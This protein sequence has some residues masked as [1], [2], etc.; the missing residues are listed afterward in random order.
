VIALDTD[1][2]VD[3]GYAATCVALYHSSPS[4]DP[5]QELHRL[6]MHWQVGT[7]TQCDEN[8][9]FE[10]YLNNGVWT[11]KITQDPRHNAVACSP[12]APYAEHTYLE[13]SHNVG[14]AV[15]GMFG[16]TP[17]D[18][19]AYAIQQHELDFYMVMCGAVCVKYNIDPLDSDNVKTHAEWAIIDDYFGERWDFARLNPSPDP[20]SVDEAILTAQ[21]MRHRMLV[22]K[23]AI[24]RAL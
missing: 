11:A 16:A 15:S 7:L 24:Q 4:L 14:C 22:C 10:T 8:Y 20:L 21:S 12:A 5:G 9:N 23:T 13:N 2:P 3:P 1:A 17:S 6:T 18:F 19:G